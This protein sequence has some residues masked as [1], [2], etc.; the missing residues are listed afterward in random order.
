MSIEE[1]RAFLAVA[2]HQ[3]FVAAATALGIAR[4][5]LRR[6]VDALEA[7]TG[8]PL[9]ER[10]R[11]GVVLTEAGRHLVERGRGVEREFTA[12]LSSVREAGASP[13][14]LVKVLLPVGLPHRVV[15][16]I[17]GMART[18]WPGMRGHLRF[19]DAPL[20]APLNDLDLLLWF[21]LDTP[22]G[23]WQCHTLMRTPLRLIATPSY[24]A[25][26]G[27]PR[28]LDDLAGHD[29]YLW[30][31]SP[32]DHALVT[33]RGSRHPVQAA[34]TATDVDLLYDCAYR[35]LGL[36]W[37][38]DAG[39]PDPAGREPHVTVLDDELGAPLELRIAAPAALASSPRL[40]IFL[41]NLEAIRTAA[42]EG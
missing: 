3:S 18:V 38:P 5:S 32:T 41:S 8:V 30:S 37:V 34:M 31:A 22:A 20:A 6:H 29:L 13:T 21:G 2:E 19:S 1:L 9:L 11:A 17:V 4:T 40:R 33:R 16:G 12:L 7:R 39:L 10:G 28:T 36:A 23:T 14:G 35:E 15:A 27:T 26:H 42:R 24:L 25:A